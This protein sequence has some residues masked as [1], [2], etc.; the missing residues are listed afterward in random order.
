MLVSYYC[1]NKLLE[2]SALK[3]HKLTFLEL[4]SEVQNES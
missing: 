1:Y 2:L 4:R 3:Q